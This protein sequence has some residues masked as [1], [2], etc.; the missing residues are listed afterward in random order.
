MPLNEIVEKY[1]IEEVCFKTN[2]SKNN[3]QALLSEDFNKIPRIQAIGFISIIERELNVD[4]SEFKK[5]AIEFYSGESED[6]GVAMH[7]AV[8]EEKKEKSSW[9]KTIVILLIIYAV[10]YAYTNL[11]KEKLNTVIPYAEEK[12]NQIINSGKKLTTEVS[13]I[14]IK[15]LSIAETAN[16]NEGYTAPE[17]IAKEDIIEEPKVENT[18][19]QEEKT[20]LIEEDNDVDTVV[21]NE[22]NN[23]VSSVSFTLNE[24]NSSY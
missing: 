19:T 16:N 17:E 2:I 21:E 9:F 5:D 10:W 8:P 14:D 1:T 12:F 18:A 15:N 13:N 22:I 24:E 11:D 20:E 7:Y 3:L 6:N 23:S 4:L